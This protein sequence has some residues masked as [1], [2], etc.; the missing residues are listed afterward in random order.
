MEL[1]VTS[2]ISFLKAASEFDGAI[3]VSIAAISGIYILVRNRRLENSLRQEKRIQLLMS[4]DK[5]P[6]FKELFTAAFGN[7]I[8]TVEQG[9]DQLEHVRNAFEAVEQLI[10]QNF[11]L[12]PSNRQRELLRLIKKGHMEEHKLQ[13]YL[14]TKIAESGKQPGSTDKKASRLGGQMLRIKG[15]LISETQKLF[16]YDYLHA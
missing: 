16:C 15:K 13:K 4:A 6:E 12:V 5:N 8:K 7:K 3:A 10:L 2:L 11:E 9:I 1:T 14:T